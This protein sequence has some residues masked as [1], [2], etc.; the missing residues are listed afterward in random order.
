[1]GWSR[2]SPTTRPITR[3]AR[4]APS[5]PITTSGTEIYWADDGGGLLPPS[6]WVVQY[7]NGSAWVNVSDQSGEPTAIN[8]FNQVTFDPVT[9]S[10][11]RVTI[12]SSGT[13]SVGVI[14]W[15]VPSIPSS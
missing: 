3:R 7:W 8:T 2:T 9:T 6:S 15:V 4:S 13:A 12:Q 10:K 5:T 1:M 14:Q 11:L